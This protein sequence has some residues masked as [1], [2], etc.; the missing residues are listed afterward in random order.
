ML[1]LRQHDGNLFCNTSTFALDVYI[2]SEHYHIFHK[3]KSLV[4]TTLFPNMLNPP[5]DSYLNSGISLNYQS[6]YIL[7]LM[8][9]YKITQQL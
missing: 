1:L 8:Q 5:L 6:L 3:E 4:P 9:V 7:I 2:S